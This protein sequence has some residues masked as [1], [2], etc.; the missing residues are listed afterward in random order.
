MGQTNE[1]PLQLPLV[2]HNSQLVQYASCASIVLGLDISQIR[3]A[4][5]TSALGSF[6][7]QAQALVSLFSPES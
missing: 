7:R 6:M 5:H 4:I 2:Q 1:R 3:H